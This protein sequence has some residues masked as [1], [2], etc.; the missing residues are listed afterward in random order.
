MAASLMG[1]EGTKEQALLEAPTRLE[2]LRMLH[3]WLAHELDVIELCN[4]IAEEAR[5]EMSREQKEYILRQQKKAIEQE[6]GEKN[7][8]QA[9]VESLREKLAA[10]DLPEDVRKEAER[11]LARLE[12]LPAVQP[13]HNVIRTWLEYVIELPWNKRSEDSL[14]LAQARRGL[15]E[16]H[17]RI[18]QRKE[19]ILEHLAVLKLNPATKAPSLCFVSTPRVGQKSLGR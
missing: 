1:L 16:G 7:P 5:G 10:A 13:E 14:D 12:K 17:F 2:A 3:G 4:K 19:R 9:E 8:D 6:L 15:G 11:E 18:T